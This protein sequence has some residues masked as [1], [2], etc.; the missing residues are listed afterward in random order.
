MISADMPKDFYILQCG[1]NVTIELNNRGQVLGAFV[2]DQAVIQT[3]EQS[4]TID[5]LW[6]KKI[7][8]H[9]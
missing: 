9:V 8:N 6:A 1:R 4:Y 7:D 3:P 2:P 5:D